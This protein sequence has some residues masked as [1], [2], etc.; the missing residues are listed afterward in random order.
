MQCSVSSEFEDD[1]L[2]VSFQDGLVDWVNEYSIEQNAVDGL[3][4]LPKDNGHPNLPIYFSFGE[5]LL[6]HFHKHPCETVKNINHLEISLKLDGL[7]LL[8]SSP[9]NVS[10]VL[11]GILTIKPV[12][13]F[14]IV[15]TC[16]DSKPKD[17]EFLDEFIEDFKGILE[18]GVQDGEKVL[19]VTVRSIVCDA[20]ARVLVKESRYKKNIIALLALSV[21]RLLIW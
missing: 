9:K 13:V 5:Q 19:T 1:S 16:G 7:S 3:L 6:K 8:K 10:P 20:P 14:P 21:T 15:R 12:V 4:A 11:F 2:N 18:R 17:L